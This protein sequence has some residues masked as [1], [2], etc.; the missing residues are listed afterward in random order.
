MAAR[1]SRKKIREE[2]LHIFA[3][4]PDWAVQKVNLLT[5]KEAEVVQMTALGKHQRVICATLGRTWNA[6]Y[7]RRRFTKSKLCCSNIRDWPR[8]WFAAQVMKMLDGE[9]MIPEQSDE[10]LE[11]ALEGIDK[12]ARRTTQ[13]N[14]FRRAPFIPVC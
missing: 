11:S 12:A 4:D 7:R 13:D 1:K 10:A 2:L 6:I 3:V 8:V 14:G 5:R 9:E